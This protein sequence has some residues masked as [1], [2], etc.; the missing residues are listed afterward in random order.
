MNHKF[1]PATTRVLTLHERYYQNHIP[2]SVASAIRSLKITSS[3]DNSSEPK[4]LRY[5]IAVVKS[6]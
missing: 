4:S 5:S 1:H 3:G 6:P 2:G